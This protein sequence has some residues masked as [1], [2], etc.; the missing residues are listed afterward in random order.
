MQLG[1]PDKVAEM[2]GRRGM[3]VRAATGKGVTY[4]ARNTWVVVCLPNYHATLHYRL[5]ISV[6]TSLE[7]MWPWKWLICMKSSSL[8]MVKSW[9]LLSLRQ[10]LLV[11]HCRLI[12]EL[13]IRCVNFFDRNH[14]AWK[15]I[16]YWT[17][18]MYSVHKLL[19]FVSHS[20][21]SNLFPTEKKGSF[22]PGTS[23]ECWPCN[24]TVWK[25]AS[26]KSSFRTR[27]Q[28]IEH[29]WLTSAFYLFD[30]FHIGSR[31]KSYWNCWVH[32]LEPHNIPNIMK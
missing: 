18:N 12:D 5:L 1:G 17:L 14:Y 31:R 19:S 11:F 21:L 2:T 30:C 9:L 20:V 10:D 8:W 7:K 32:P 13:Q 23:M 4:Q 26:I 3:L 16:V 25:N 28:V 15:F 24:S 29:Y 22:N 6:Y 27:I